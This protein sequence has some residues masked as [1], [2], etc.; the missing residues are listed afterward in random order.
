MSDRL[1]EI[2]PKERILTEEQMDRHTTFRTGGPARYFLVI[3]TRK[4]LAQVLAWLQEEALPWFLLGNGS[5]LW[6][7]TGLPA[8]R[9]CIWRGIF[10]D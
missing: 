6:W 3:E 8:A 9:S 5:N 10:K 2:L 4:E 1:N 7:V